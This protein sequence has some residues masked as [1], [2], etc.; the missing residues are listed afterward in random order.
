MKTTADKALDLIAQEPDC[1]RCAEG[2]S[3]YARIAAA[4]TVSDGTRR[5]LVCVEDP[6]HRYL[7]LRTGWEVIFDIDQRDHM[8][9]P[10][11]MAR[12]MLDKLED[13]KFG[14][15]QFRSEMTPEGEQYVIPGCEADAAPSVSQLNLF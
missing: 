2:V 4:G 11:Q 1:S 7:T 15:P 14:K 8:G 13:L 10:S 3:T 6:G 5:L 9:K 12:I